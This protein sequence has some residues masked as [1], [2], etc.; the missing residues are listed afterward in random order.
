MTKRVD[1]R[2]M[3]LSTRRQVLMAGAAAGAALLLPRM[4]RAATVPF[5]FECDR[6]SAFLMDPNQHK[7][8]GYVTDFAGLGVTTP[9]ARDL[10]VSVPWNA[11]SNPAYAGLGFT[12]PTKTVPNASAKVVGVIEKFSWAGGVGDA[13]EVEFW[14]SQQNALQIKSLQ[15]AILK[16]TTVSA[17]GWW[18]ADYD[19]EKK[20]W[21]EESYPILPA[22][23]SG[24]VAG[25]PNPDLNVNLTGVPVKDGI[26]V[27]VYKVALKLAPAANAAHTLQF[28]NAAYKPVVKSWGLTVGTLAGAAVPQ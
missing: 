21:F 27:M 16:N 17:L 15:Q 12:P 6:A 9:L 2:A 18:I 4:A 24:V 25:K 23:V 22:K 20:L 13:L 3:F 10:A 19:Q 7:R 28:A 11:G 5:N 1:E 14:V 26:D 8:F